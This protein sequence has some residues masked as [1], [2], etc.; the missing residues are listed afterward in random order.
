MVV[1]DLHTTNV[2]SA[3]RF[4]KLGVNLNSFHDLTVAQI[5]VRSQ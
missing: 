2:E 5:L 3:H 4:R 1:V